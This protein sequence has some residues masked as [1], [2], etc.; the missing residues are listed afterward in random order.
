MIGQTY[1]TSNN[2]CILKFID[3]PFDGESG[4]F[5]H[6]KYDSIQF[7]DFEKRIT[8][9]YK[10]YCQREYIFDREFKWGR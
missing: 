9:I 10:L 1:S 6:N 3:G 4:L 8:Y 5:V 7:G 2:A